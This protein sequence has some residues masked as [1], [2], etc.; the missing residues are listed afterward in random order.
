M[1]RG[2]CPY[3]A[4]VCPTDANRPQGCSG[5]RGTQLPPPWKC[6]LTAWAKVACQ[7]GICTVPTSVL[8]GKE[9]GRNV[10]LFTYHPLSSGKPS[11]L[12]GK[13]GRLPEAQ[14]GSSGGSPSTDVQARLLPFLLFLRW[15]SFCH[16]DGALSRG[17]L[18]C[19]ESGR[20]GLQPFWNPLLTAAVDCPPPVLMSWSCCDKVPQAWWLNTRE[21]YSLTVQAAMSP[22]SRCCQGRAPSVDSGEESFLT[23]SQLWRLLAIPAGPW[24]L[25]TSHGLLPSSLCPNFLLLMSTPATG[26]QPSPSSDLTLTYDIC[27]QPISK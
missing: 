26:R 9:L 11:I 27:K 2:T 16:Q 12:N 5:H 14:A 6:L 19:K 8:V 20:T 4:R 10:H 17:C 18:F 24:L 22:Q 7:P 15:S 13:S 1:S 3:I 23:S 21:I 25:G